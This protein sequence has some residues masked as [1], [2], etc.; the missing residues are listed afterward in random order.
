MLTIKKKVIFLSFLGIIPF[1][2]DIF[3]SYLSNSYNFKLFQQVNL[4]SFLYGGLITSFLCG[5]Q[6]VKFIEL[7]KNFLY[8]PLIP[9]ILIW[10]SFFF[11]E[12]IFFQF[13]VIISLLWCLFVDISVLKKE[14]KLWFKK[15]N[16]DCCWRCY[17]QYN[18]GNFSC[19][20]YWFF[21]K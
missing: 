5:M 14:N 7:K 19:V 12:K 18:T 1:Y 4:V 6:W 10:I 16:L 20:S 8:I 3:V 11:S 21:F 15:I 17:C 2:F 9:P 13:T